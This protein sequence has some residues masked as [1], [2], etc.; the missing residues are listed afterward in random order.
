MHAAGYSQPR[1]GAWAPSLVGGGFA[2]R[3]MA[4]QLPCTQFLFCFYS[5]SRPRPA[6]PRKSAATTQRARLGLSAQPFSRRLRSG[7][8]PR[9]DNNVCRAT[10]NGPAS[11][12]TCSV[13][14]SHGPSRIEARRRLLSGASLHRVPCDARLRLLR[15]R[16]LLGAG[17][18]L[19]LQHLE[20][21]HLLSADAAYYAQTHS[22]HA[23]S[24]PVYQPCN[25][26][27]GGGALVSRRSKR[28]GVPGA[29]LRC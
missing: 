15:C 28:R 20:I 25:R 19:M 29:A 3:S 5:F 14:E 18:Q 24:R 26:G 8:V 16:E 9:K 17:H 27:C 1:L 11:L 6:D 2:P 4:G 12:C 7:H 21:P 22:Q 23:H 10:R 13:H